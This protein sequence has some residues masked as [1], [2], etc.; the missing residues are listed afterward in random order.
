MEGLRG[1]NISPIPS[2]HFRSIPTEPKK[3]IVLHIIFQPTI[4][5]TN[6]QQYTDKPAACC[7]YYIDDGLL[8]T[9]FVL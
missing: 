7:I 5:Y 3:N 1:Q 4:L 6:F 8:N 2:S 9:S